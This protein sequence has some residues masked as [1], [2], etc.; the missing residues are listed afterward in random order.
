MT[1]PDLP[2]L[3]STF[4]CIGAKNNTGI[5]R[6]ALSASD[7]EARLL[8]IKTML[9]DGLHV[10]IDEIGN[11]Y[12]LVKA[13][14]DSDRLVLT[15]SHLDSQPDGGRFDGQVG[16]LASLRVV[17]GCKERVWQ[18][19]GIN[20][21]VVNWTNEEGARFQPSLMG[22]SVFTGVLS[23]EDAV[24]CIDAQGVCVSEALD[25]FRSSLASG[26]DGLTQ[27]EMTS[28]VSFASASTLRRATVGYAELHVEQ[29][30]RL[31]SAGIDVGVVDSIWSAYKTDIT[32]IG[33][34]THTGS[35]PM[36]KR[37]DAL[38]AAS[39]AVTSIFELGA[40][41]PDGLLHTAVA[42]MQI[43]PNSP[44]ATPSKVRFKVEL[45]SACED[46]V[47]AALSSFTDQLE[48]LGEACGVQFQVEPW[49]ARPA[50]Q[51]AGSLSEDVASLLRD[52][53][54]SVMRLS[55]IAGHDAVALSNAGIPSILLFVT[56]VAGITHN[57]HE[58][59]SDSD[60]V[61]GESALV[62]AVNQL[63][64]NGQN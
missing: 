17:S 24:N 53:G 62:V 44:N 10:Y 31:E 58:F 6:L 12:G 20:L 26:C 40:G 54:L 37:R 2:S 5:E 50:S 28:R 19:S 61:K 51:L 32:V 14:T 48:S 38:Y 47:R 27:H 57:H 15:G 23:I 59:T 33:E 25:S 30:D 34:Q 7:I 36:C 13:L 60:L 8:L 63:I 9:N 22:S 39:R 4:S 56:S 29:G 49:S 3:M 35:T 64:F 1:L 18:Q 11:I 52:N 46:R 45:R 43:V 41:D 21:G 16:V 42:W 55:T